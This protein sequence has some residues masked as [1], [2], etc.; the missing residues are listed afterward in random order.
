MKVIHSFVDE[1]RLRELRELP[2]VNWDLTRLVRLCEELNESFADG[3]YHAV[4]FLTRAVLDHVPPIFG[5][6]NFAAVANNYAGSKSFRHAMQSLDSFARKIADGQLHQQVRGQEVLPTIAQVNCSSALDLLLSE[7]VRISKAAA[8]QLD[9]VARKVARAQELMPDFLCPKCE[10][11]IE[12]R[13]PGSGTVSDDRGDYALD[14]D[15][16]WEDVY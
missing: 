7:I 16:D 12:K 2:A 9:A 4:A 5:C 11:P 8:T 14:Y 3:S 13:E 6:A 15:V 1:V 10:A